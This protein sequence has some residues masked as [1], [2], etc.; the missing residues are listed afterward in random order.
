LSR[1]ARKFYDL[2]VSEGEGLGTVYE[3]M[4]KYRLLNKVV[5]KNEKSKVLI[6]GLPEKYGY[7]LDFISFCEENNS[8]YDILDER[9]GKLS[10]LR[11]ILK[12]SNKNPGAVRLC[13]LSG[14]ED[15]YANKSFDLALSCEVLQ[16]LSPDNQIRYVRSLKNIAKRVILF[17]PNGD[18]RCHQSH[19]GLNGVKMQALIKQL[20]ITDINKYRDAG[21]VDMPPWPPGVKNNPLK[22][23][24]G[25]AICN[26][27]LSILRVISAIE[28]FYP[29]LFKLKYAHLIYMVW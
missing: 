20:D 8:N 23:G 21:Y 27:S 13:D 6:A 5:L 15:I 2:A 11:R 4:V 10:V 25:R 26:I 28:P 29:G 14:I 3:Y 16:R 18:N 22:G 19:S 24:V 12:K 17:V 7:S 1:L 9:T